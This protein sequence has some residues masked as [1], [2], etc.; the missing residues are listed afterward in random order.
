MPLHKLSKETREK[1]AQDH[2]RGLMTVAELS[3]KYSLYPNVVRVALKR[4]SVDII[5]H[6]RM[7]FNLNAFDDLTSEL[8]VYWLGFIYADGYAS[9]DALRINIK[10]DDGPHLEFFKEFMGAGYPIKHAPTMANGKINDRLSFGINSVKL[11]RHLQ[12]LGIVVNRK[13]EQRNLPAMYDAIPDNVKHHWF[14]GIFDGDGCAQKRG[15]IVMLASV[16]ILDELK[17]ICSREG[18]FTK[19]RNS[20]NGPSV[21]Y[22]GKTGRI[23]IGGVAQARRLAD[24]LYRDATVF[25]GRKREIVESWTDKSYLL[26]KIA[27]LLPHMSE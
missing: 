26:G 20:P 17:T 1:I 10:T 13:R 11:S 24:Y 15:S 23:S 14:R 16:P 3:R 18:V 19:R 4:E 25:L 7:T 8:P 2:T 27:T 21:R 6:G 22:V 9:G 5:K 12:S